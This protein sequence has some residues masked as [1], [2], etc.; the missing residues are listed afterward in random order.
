MKPEPHIFH[1]IPLRRVEF[2]SFSAEVYAKMRQE[3]E[4]KELEMDALLLLQ[5]LERHFEATPFWSS[6]MKLPE[7][8]VDLTAWG[9]AHRLSEL[10]REHPA[11]GLIYYWHDLHFAYPKFFDAPAA[12][13]RGDLVDV[14]MFLFA[15]EV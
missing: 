10:R 5:M 4:K 13:W 12:G 7:W 9:R 1:S 15:N 8:V 2:T 14:E 3:F 6:D 11:V